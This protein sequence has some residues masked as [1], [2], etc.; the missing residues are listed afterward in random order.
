MGSLRHRNVCARTGEW[1]VLW[2]SRKIVARCYQDTIKRH[3]KEALKQFKHWAKKSTL[4]DK[5]DENLKLHPFDKGSEFVIMKEEEAI[6]RIEEQ[7]IYNRLWCNINP[8]A[9]SLRKN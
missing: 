9:L 8:I 2:K 7:I 4:R 3:K 1:R 5:N 6:K